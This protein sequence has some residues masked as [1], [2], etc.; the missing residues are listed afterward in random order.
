M[1]NK[2]TKTHEFDLKDLWRVFLSFWL[3]IA[4]LTAIG[5]VGGG[6]YSLLTDKTVYTAYA[7]FWVNAKSV[8]G[9]SQSSTM[10]AA[11]LATNYVELADTTALLTRAVKDGDLASKW[12]TTEDRAVKT[13]GSMISAGKTDSDSIMFTVYIRSGNAQMTYDA[14]S[15][16]QQSMITVIN[17]VNDDGEVIRVAEVYSMDDVYVSRPSA[18]KKA[19]IGAC[20]GFVLSYAL[21]LVVFMLDKRARSTVDVTSETGLTVVSL[22]EHFY[23]KHL[24]K[25]ISPE[26]AVCSYISAAERVVKLTPDGRKTIAIT[27]TAY[28]DPD[29]ALSVAEIYAG[30]GK[31]TLVV[32]CDSR[33]PL[34]G[35]MLGVDAE[36]TVGLDKYVSDGN[37]PTVINVDDCLDTIVVGRDGSGYLSIRHLKSLL[38]KIGSE[39]ELVVLSLPS[40]ELMTDLS[41]LSE[42]A[43]GNVISI[44]FGDRTDDI[45]KVNEQLSSLGVTVNAVYFLPI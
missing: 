23:G 4:I 2:M 31:R 9:V 12:N 38:E 22:P 36:S 19:V 37:M 30:N 41:I 32:E 39:Y 21:A 1:E 14:I 20:V 29:A 15:A 25:R 34:I 11:Q 27:P 17:D 43:D 28:A 3:I 26:E 16:V 18:I 10:G 40:V 6:V 45:E 13:L 35:E 33:M 24:T 8:G 44:S 42:I 5:G 7:S